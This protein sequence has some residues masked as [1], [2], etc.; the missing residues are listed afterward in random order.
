MTG[1]PSGY[2][3]EALQKKARSDSSDQAFNRC[4][5]ISAKVIASGVVEI[6]AFCE[7]DWA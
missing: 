5:R 4:M 7:D 3:G 6:A 2:S 1:R